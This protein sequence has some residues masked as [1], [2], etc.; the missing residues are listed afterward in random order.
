MPQPK[1]V[2]LISGGSR[3]LGAKLVSGFIERRYGV[4]TLSRTK[5]AFINDM[6]R[7]RRR[8]HWSSVDGRD[9]EALRALIQATLDRWLASHQ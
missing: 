3:G 7:A 1:K 4:A 6:L 2:A 9:H 8:F 5:T